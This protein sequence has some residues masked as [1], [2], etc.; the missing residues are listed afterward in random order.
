MRPSNIDLAE[1]LSLEA[2]RA[3]GTVSR[4]FR[5]AAR[6]SFTWSEEAVS[7]V[8]Q[9][10]SLTELAGVGP[11]L[12]R[13]IAEWIADE[14]IPPPPP[15]IR[16]GFLSL[17]GA[18]AILGTSPLAIQGDLQMH[19]T[20]SDGGS[21]LTQ[22][23]EAAAARGYAYV[24][25]TDHSAGLR[26]VRGL[27]EAALERQ[28][29]EIEELN[30][31]YRKAGVDLQVLR[32]VEMNLNPR[33]E[34]D[35]EP[36]ALQR[37]DLVLGSFHSALRR[38]EDQTERYLAAIRNPNVDV[39]AHPRGRIY[40]YRVGLTADWDRVFV[41][42][43]EADIAIEIDAYPDRQDL[44]VELLNLARDAGT[45]I[46]IGT[47]AHHHPQLAWIDLGVA[48]AV[49]AQIPEGRILNL[50]PLSELCVWAKSRR[51]GE[52]GSSG[53]KGRSVRQPA[54]RGRHSNRSS[55]T[56]RGKGIRRDTRR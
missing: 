55:G 54:A 12:A 26:I 8:A 13:Y 36:T 37:L 6:R 7:L 28:R 21:T 2:E 17:T 10:R 3:E 19:T 32:S 41:A 39:L 4:A 44:D 38:T 33:G 18:R 35:L 40:N 15:P 56:T 51:H 30:A 24:A 46:S 20:W 52:R 23:A 29:V 1:L 16:T 22:M 11:F 50:M 9:D 53:T 34:G 49:A 42:A 43:A 48:A 27:D 47:D 31:S 14:R 45:R 5:R 25:I